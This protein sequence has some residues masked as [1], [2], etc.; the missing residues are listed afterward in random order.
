MTTRT[1]TTTA[2]RAHAA[3]LYKKGASLS[4]IAKALDRPYSTARAL[5]LAGGV[6]LR[7]AGCHHKVKPAPTRNAKAKTKA[8]RPTRKAARAC[9]VSRSGVLRPR[10]ITVKARGE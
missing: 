9:L 10:V 1:P 7:I 6:T 8:K 3:R 4:D 5:V 2:E